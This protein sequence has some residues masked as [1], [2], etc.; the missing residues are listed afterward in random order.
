MVLLKGKGFI[1]RPIKLKDSQGY[2]EVMQDKETIKG[3]MNFPHSFEESKREVLG[4]I[5][6]SKTKLTEV[7]TIEVNGKYAGNV[8]LDCQ[9]WNLNSGEGR[10]HLWLH[11]KFRG[12]GLATKALRLLVKY[13]FEKR[14][15]NVIYAQCKKSNKAMC[16]VNKK[17]G[18]KKVEDRMVNGIKKVWW[19]IKK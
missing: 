2:W 11:P 7:F 5:N 10:I 9:N 15:F 16:K 12:N 19:E 6:K 3:F 1:L 4:H 8:K 17:V 13:S 14:K 18:F